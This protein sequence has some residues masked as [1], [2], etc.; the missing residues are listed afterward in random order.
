M[1]TLLFVVLSLSHVQLFCDPMDRSPPGSF[2]HGISPGDLPDPGI[3]PTSPALAGGFF[4]T[5]PPGNPKCLLAVLCLATQLCSTLYNSMDCSPP[6][7]SVHEDS[8]GKNTGVGCHSLLQGIFL[9]QEL[10]W[11]LLHC[12]GFCTNWATR[13]AQVS[14]YCVPNIM[15]PCRF[16]IST[17]LQQIFLASTW[18]HKSC[19]VTN[20]KI[21]QKEIFNKWFCQCIKY[22]RLQKNPLVLKVSSE[23][24]VDIYISLEIW[25]NCL[26]TSVAWKNSLI[27]PCWVLWMSILLHDDFETSP[28]DLCFCCPCAWIWC[29]LNNPYVYVRPSVEHLLT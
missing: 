27:T 4:T 24:Y 11:G 29:F 5:E 22:L 7:S 20:L 17:E 19:V 23:I 26:G 25:S 8:P 18:R 2:V 14:T 13:E 16:H 21:E 10:N 3:E 1:S 28:R 12:R 9:T 6:G 15:V